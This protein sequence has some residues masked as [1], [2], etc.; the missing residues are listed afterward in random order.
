MFS[1]GYLRVVVNSLLIE[2]YGLGFSL[3]T[4]AVGLTGCRIFDPFYA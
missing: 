4:I 3:L 2:I 1:D